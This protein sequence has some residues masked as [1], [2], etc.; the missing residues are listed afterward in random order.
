MNEASQKTRIIVAAAILL[1]L[2]VGAFQ[3]LAGIQL[4]SQVQVQEMINAW[5]VWGYLFYILFGVT[6]VVIVPINFSLIGMAAAYVYGFWTAFL[7]N[8]G[9][10]VIGNFLAFLIGRYFGDIAFKYM[11]NKTRETYQN[12]AQS[13]GAVIAYFVMSFIPFAP[14]DF[15]PFFLGSSDMQKR[16]FVIISFVSNIGTAFSLAY[17]GSG[18]AFD[19]PLV[20]AGLVL[21]I[22]IGLSWLHR[23][24]KKFG[25]T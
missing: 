10:K 20:F 4:P 21:A 13:E 2:A 5:G 23:N 25:L 15:L 18:R 9:I 6:A 22:I 8:W 12:I 3:I 19:N 24:K 1:I 14:S 16:I 11:S 17:L 7:T